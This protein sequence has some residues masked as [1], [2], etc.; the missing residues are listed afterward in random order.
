L[1][2]Q[3]GEKTLVKMLKPFRVPWLKE[4]S[5]NNSPAQ[6]FA[7]RYLKR[8]AE[9]GEVRSY[10]TLS[11]KG[12]AFDKDL[13]AL[14]RPSHAEAGPHVAEAKR[15]G[16]RMRLWGQ[17]EAAPMEKS[18]LAK[19]K[20]VVSKTNGCSMRLNFVA[21]S[22]QEYVWEAGGPRNPKAAERGL[23]G[24]PQSGGKFRR[25]LKRRRGQ[26]VSGSSAPDQVF[27][28]GSH[29]ESFWGSTKKVSRRNR[30]VWGGGEQE[31]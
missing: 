14:V 27:T 4:A 8:K 30:K 1:G 7:G 18:K 9:G 16:E 26:R 22:A 3:W 5:G 12:L 10:R 6:T 21:T 19:R 24:R 31:T 11:A 17:G 13:R 28:R 2:V 29:R 20:I 15:K 25:R 23:E